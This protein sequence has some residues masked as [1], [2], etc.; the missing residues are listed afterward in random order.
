MKIL[1]AIIG[2]FFIG[3]AIVAI[4]N[5]VIEESEMRAHS[6]TRSTLLTSRQQQR[7]HLRQKRIRDFWMKVIF[8]CIGIGA[9]LVLSTQIFF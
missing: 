2:W 1:F 5:L 3:L 8:S 4:L 9:T 6:M 7:E